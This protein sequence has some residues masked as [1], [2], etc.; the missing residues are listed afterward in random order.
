MSDAGPLVFKS[1]DGG[2]RSDEA[3]LKLL[4]LTATTPVSD[5]KK[6]LGK[7]LAK[8]PLKPDDVAKVRH[9]KNI[10]ESLVVPL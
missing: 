5:A 3:F 9:S 2:P 8:L 7:Q 1:T 6:A 4:A 10:G